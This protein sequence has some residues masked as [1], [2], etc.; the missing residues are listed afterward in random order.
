MHA[1]MDFGNTYRAGTLGSQLERTRLRRQARRMSLVVAALT[2][3]AAEAQE[4]GRGTPRPLALALGDFRRE[5]RAVEHRL[6]Q[7]EGR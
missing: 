1:N 7:L 4:Q 3:R 2:T 6:G 5:L